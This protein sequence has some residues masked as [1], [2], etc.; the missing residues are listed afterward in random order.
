MV[1]KIISLLLIL[2]LVACSSE[3]VTQKD[4]AYQGQI[5]KIAEQSFIVGCPI[6]D[7]SCELIIYEKGVF[8]VVIKAETILDE[9]Q[10]IA[11]M[12]EDGVKSTNLAPQIGYFGQNVR[13][14]DDYLGTVLQGDYND[15]D[16]LEVILILNY[17]SDDIEYEYYVVL[18][19]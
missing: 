7:V 15:A 9:F 16:S 6:Q 5:E 14:G 18:Q 10:A 17:E 13:L 12:Y 8:E 19:G 1:K 2:F 3:V 4:A 11:V